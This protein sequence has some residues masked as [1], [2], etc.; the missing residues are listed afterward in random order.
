MKIK[1]TKMVA[2]GNDF[3]VLDNRNKKFTQNALSK[4]A[5]KVCRRKMSVGADGLL[6]V[7]KSKAADFRMRIFNPDGSEPEM[8][9]NGARCIALYAK[10][11]KIAGSSM[12]FQTKAGKI[13]AEVKKEGINQSSSII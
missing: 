4:I 5:K 1:F 10:E 8:C 6:V 3:V 12:T 13:A 11:N 2:S 7:E 9:G